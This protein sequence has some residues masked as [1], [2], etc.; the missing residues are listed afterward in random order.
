[1][2]ENLLLSYYNSLCFYGKLLLMEMQDS[3]LV[4]AANPYAWFVPG[5]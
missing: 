3:K 4:L 2:I 5:I 1:M